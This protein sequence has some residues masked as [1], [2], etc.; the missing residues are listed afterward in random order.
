M[1]A[2][3]VEAGGPAES[4]D[5]RAEVLR[6]GAAREMGG[7]VLVALELVVANDG[8]PGRPEGW[9]VR[10]RLTDGTTAELPL[11]DLAEP[12]VFALPDGSDRTVEPASVLPGRLRERPIE[13]DDERTGTLVCG[14]AGLG[15]EELLGNGTTYVVGFRDGEGGEVEARLLVSVGPVGDEPEY[16]PG[17]GGT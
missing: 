1:T 12:V 17:L 11:R 5:F 2:A 13:R 15:A 10:V 4:P 3:S 7:G 9:S 6:V 16:F 8:A 14:G